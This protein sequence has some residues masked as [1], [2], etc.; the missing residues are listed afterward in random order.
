MYIDRMKVKFNDFIMFE[1]P[2]LFLA[3]C[4]SI[5]MIEHDIQ[6]S[7]CVAGRRKVEEE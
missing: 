5:S 2:V 7:D 4:L 6:R 3:D 1:R